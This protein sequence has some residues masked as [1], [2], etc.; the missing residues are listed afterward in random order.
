MP[1]NKPVPVNS[2]IREPIYR[3]V[4]VKLMKEQAELIGRLM[5]EDDK[6]II[7]VDEKRQLQGVW[8]MLHDIMDDLEF[9]KESVLEI[10]DGTN[11]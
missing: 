10:H 7:Q 5:D 8:N 11:S 2:H 1:K 3:K 4:D 6:V 9:G